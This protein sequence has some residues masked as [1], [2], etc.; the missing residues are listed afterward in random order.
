MLNKKSYV[1]T[2]MAIILLSLAMTVDCKYLEELKD[3]N[4]V[5]NANQVIEVYGAAIL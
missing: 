1:V 2:L 5:N 3:I 4:D